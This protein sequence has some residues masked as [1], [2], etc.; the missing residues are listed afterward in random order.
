[1]KILLLGG[2]GIL[3]SEICLLALNK[4]YDVSMINR[5]KRKEN[6]DSRATIIISDLK[7]DE[8]GKIRDKMSGEVYDVVIDFVSYNVKQLARTTEFIKGKCKQFIFISSATAYINKNDNTPYKETDLVGDTGWSYAYDKVKCEKYLAENKNQL[9]FEYTIIR[10][11]VTFGKTRIPYQVIP[12]EYFTIINRIIS[13]KPILFFGKDVYCT[14]TTSKM[15]AVGVVGLFLNERAYNEAIHITSSKVFVWRKIIELLAEQLNEKPDLVELTTETL[16]KGARILGFDV[17]EILY[18]KSRNMVFDNKKVKEL[19]PDFDD[20]VDI[21]SALKESLKYF[22]NNKESQKINYAW[23]AR[24]DSLLSKH[25]PNIPT[26]Q[27]S[28]NGYK[29]SLS[30][31]ERKEYICNRYDILYFF[32]KTIERISRKLAGKIA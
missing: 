10:P 24:I 7:N 3:S 30:K 5:G 29:N 13:K 4:G 1:M 6:I 8:V 14:L 27:L 23:D 9:G 26:R 25:F 20:N 2:S 15:F 11:Y 19:V 32:M 18:D 16:H 21:E 28:L 22:L 31:K 17:N 12:L